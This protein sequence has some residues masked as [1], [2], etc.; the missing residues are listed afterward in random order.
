[1]G[2]YLNVRCMHAWTEV[3]FLKQQVNSH[4]ST[5]NIAENLPTDSCCRPLQAYVN[6]IRQNGQNVWK[7]TICSLQFKFLFP[8]F[9]I[10]IKN[11]FQKAKKIA[12]RFSF[13]LKKNLFHVYILLFSKKVIKQCNA[14]DGISTFLFKWNISSPSLSTHMHMFCQQLLQEYWTCTFPPKLAWNKGHWVLKVPHILS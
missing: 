13:S 6:Y 10:P 14:K 3:P 5:G 9:L 2:S 7:I 11:R 1:M 4:L 12:C 8:E